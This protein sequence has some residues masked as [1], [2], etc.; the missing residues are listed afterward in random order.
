MIDKLWHDWQKANPANFWS[1]GG[2]SVAVVN[3]S[4]V[5]PNFPT[6]ALPFVNV[7]GLLISRCSVDEPSRSSLHRSQQMGF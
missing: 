2:G 3:G 4:V 1:F 6:G 7:R 5:D